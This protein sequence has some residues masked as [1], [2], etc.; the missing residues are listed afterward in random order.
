MAS[1]SAAAVM[2]CDT[3]TENPTHPTALPLC[4]FSISRIMPSSRWSPEPRVVRTRVT[5]SSALDLRGG[6]INRVVPMVYTWYPRGIHMASTCHSFIRSRLKRRFDCV[7]YT[8]WFT[9]S[10]PRIGGGEM[11]DRRRNT[12]CN[13][14]VN[15][16]PRRSR[17]SPPD[18][19]WPRC[20]APSRVKRPPPSV[21]PVGR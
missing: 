16:R 10:A 1:I 12:A 21:D 11:R 17:A 5:R 4:L 9:R 18:R 19:R 15:G 14:R 2:R 20:E 8:R 6:Y 3:G 7:V 13:L